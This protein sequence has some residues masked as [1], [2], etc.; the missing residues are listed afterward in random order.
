MS[1]ENKAPLL[2]HF[3]VQGTNQAGALD[4]DGSNT[5]LEI[6]SDDFLHLKDEE[7]ACVRGVSKDGVS[8]S[9]IH[10]VPLVLSGGASYHGKH[11]HFRALWLR[12]GG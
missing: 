3:T 10:C 6:F 7:M 11:K 12:L 9:A 4:L 5:K 2:G 1:I 8:I